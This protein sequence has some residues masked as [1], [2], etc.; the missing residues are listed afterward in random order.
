MTVKVLTIPHALAI[1]AKEW[2]DRAFLTVDA[3]GKSLTFSQAHRAVLNLVDYLKSLDLSP[4]ARVA[5]MGPNDIEFPLVWLA[6]ASA[7][8]VIVPINKTFQDK[9]AHYILEHS[10]AEAIVAAPDNATMVKSLSARLPKLRHIVCWG[11]A[12]EVERVIRGENGQS[13]GAGMSVRPES[14]A[15][16]QY[17]SGTTGL[18]KGCVL[19]HG[20]WITLGSSLRDYAPRLTSDDTI[21]TAQAFSYIDPPWNVIAALLT[22]A[23][24]VVLD[25]FHPSSFME[26]IRQYKVTFFY[27]LGAMPTLLLAMPPSPRDRAHALR[28]ISCS[29]IPPSR[30]TELE[31][32]F[33]VPWFEGYGATETGAVCAIDDANHDDAVGSGCLGLPLANR[34]VRIVDEDDMSV[35]PGRDGELVVRGAW[36]M[37]R[38]FKNDGATQIAFRSGWYHTG[39]IAKMDEAGRLYFGR[40]SKDMIRRSGENVSAVEVEETLNAHPKVL[41]SACVAVR[42][43]L[44]EEE[45]KAFIVPTEGTLD[46]GDFREIAA[47]CAA[48]IARFKVPRY[49]VSVSNLP[50]TPSERVMKSDLSRL[51]EGF[52]LTGQG[53][54][55]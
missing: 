45:V 39:D 54:R 24:L 14:T 23:H 2:P 16:I 15:A 4:G 13:I 20:F 33:G 48:R 21:L 26:K 17:T 36:M 55:A 27:C 47:F 52:D 7:G 5:V 43:N 6:I 12:S 30:Q 44:R 38:Y 22:G 3:Q 41:L 51:A 25:G 50:L 53:A 29:A 19:S 11:P 35:G 9:D 40:R 31:K 37:D 1:A 10:D 49:W 8:Y 28:Q 32:R 42:D 34:E 46:E 18:P